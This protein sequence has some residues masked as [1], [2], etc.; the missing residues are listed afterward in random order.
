MMDNVLGIGIVRDIISTVPMAI[1]VCHCEKSDHIHT[2]M[3]VYYL[4]PVLVHTVGQ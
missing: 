1:V 4:C 2:Q 3:A